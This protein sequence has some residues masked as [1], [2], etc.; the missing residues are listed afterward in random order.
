[1]HQRDF[2]IGNLRAN[3]QGSFQPFPHANRSSHSNHIRHTG[4]RRVTPKGENYF[5]DDPAA[6]A[7]CSAGGS[8][9]PGGR[10]PGPGDPPAEQPV[11]TAGSSP[12]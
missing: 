1:V 2:P 12:K 7:G 9:G 4:Y 6:A 5:G 11:A 10:P 8:P 3:Q